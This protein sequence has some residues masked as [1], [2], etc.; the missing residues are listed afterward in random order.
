M[1]YVAT[2]PCCTSKLIP[3]RALDREPGPCAPLLGL[4]AYGLERSAP[5]ILCGDASAG[6]STP[7]RPV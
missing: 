5:C 2:K 7:S 4:A 6:S 3:S 1:D